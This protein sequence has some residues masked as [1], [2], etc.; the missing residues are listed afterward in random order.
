MIKDSLNKFIKEKLN[1]ILSKNQLREVITS[2]RLSRMKTKRNNSKLISFS[3]N[4]YLGLSQNL[5]IKKVAIQAVKKYGV[6]SGAS[7]LI[8]GNNPL[9]SELERKLASVKEAE[10]ACVF[11]S[12]FLANIGVIPSLMGKGDIIFVDEFSH[13]STFLGIRLSNAYFKTF[14]HNNMHDL[15]RKIKFYRNRYRN[16]LILTEG[17]FSMDGD[18]APLEEVSIL[19]KDS[20]SWLMVDDAHGFGVVGKGKGCSNLYSPKPEIDI[21]MGTLSKAIGSYGGFVCGSRNLIRLIV[22][23]A[24]S[25]IYT[26]GLPPSVIAASLAAINLIEKNSK[27]SEIPLENAKLFSSLVNLPEPKSPIVPVFLK[28]EK[29]VLEASK[30]LENA[31]FLVGAIRPPTVP[32]NSSRLRITFSASHTKHQVRELASEIINLNFIK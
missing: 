1:E 9:Y 2:H 10:A 15:K 22:N 8:T 32:K 29:K 11:G 27:I 17:V 18:L 14:N 28:S 24:R 4:D 7:R 30:K 31:G 19:A 13:A 5:I 3:C 21:H 26:T 12:G 16:C 23:R 20:D 6:G 25:Q